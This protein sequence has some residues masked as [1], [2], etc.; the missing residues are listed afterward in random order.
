M[1]KFLTS[2]AAC[3]LAL[4]GTQVHALGFAI[5]DGGGNS[6]DITGTGFT[7]SGIR[8]GEF[9][10]TPNGLDGAWPS[11]VP[12]GSFASYCVQVTESFSFG[13]SPLSGYTIKPFTTAADYPGG[14]IPPNQPV[15]L[16]QL[17]RIGKLMTYGYSASGFGSGGISNAEATA[18]QAGI[19]EVIY[20]PSSDPSTFDITTG[21]FRVTSTISTE[22]STVNTWMGAAGGATMLTSYQK[23]AVLHSWGKQD[24][25]VPV[26]E[27]EAYGLAL[28]GLGVVALGMRRRRKA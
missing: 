28:A 11:Y 15:S 18:L 23:Y 1:K 13:D 27:P 17:D 26:P 10:I 5:V 8:G 4:A 24:F 20:Q 6:M 2:V 12:P 19:W 14:S 16:A 25:L 22:M 9:L 21:T 7:K 3:G